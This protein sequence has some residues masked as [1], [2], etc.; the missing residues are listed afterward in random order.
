MTK[1][2]LRA[3]I[4]ELEMQVAPATLSGRIS[5]LNIVLN[6]IDPNYDDSLLPKNKAMTVFVISK[7][8]QEIIKTT[9]VERGALPQWYSNIIQAYPSSLYMVV[10]CN[11]SIA[12]T[13]LGFATE[14]EMQKSNLPFGTTKWEQ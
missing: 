11:L 14:E 3:Y 2:R 4:A 10:A 1:E 6:L 13:I 7:S 5:D 12:G 8:N 9:V